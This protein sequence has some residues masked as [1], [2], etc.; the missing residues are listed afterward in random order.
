MAWVCFKRLFRLLAE[1]LAPFAFLFLLAGATAA[2]EII[3]TLRL[4]HS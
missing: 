3:P 4:F 2:D 1:G